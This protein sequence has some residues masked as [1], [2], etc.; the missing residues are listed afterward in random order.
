MRKT[1]TKEEMKQAIDKVLEEHYD[2]LWSEELRLEI[3]G[4]VRTYLNGLDV[5]P[6]SLWVYIDDDGS[7]C[8]NCRDYTAIDITR[9]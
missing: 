8:V 1:P 9:N 6:K 2:K 3:E 5:D 4:Q 7:V